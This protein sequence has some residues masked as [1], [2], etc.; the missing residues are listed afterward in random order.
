L[1]N[2]N[3]Q[4]H[5]Y[6]NKRQQQ[7]QQ[8]QQHQQQQQRPKRAFEDDGTMWSELQPDAHHP[9]QVISPED[10]CW[11]VQVAHYPPLYISRE[12]DGA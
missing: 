9:W 4:N 10:G 6:V 8:Q 12:P 5:N 1:P 7:Q 3:N 2:S 11:A